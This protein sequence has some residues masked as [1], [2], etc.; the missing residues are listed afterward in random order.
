MTTFLGRRGAALLLYLAIAAFGLTACQGARS[1]SNTLAP[2][3]PTTAAERRGLAYLKAG[4]LNGALEQYDIALAQGAS[5]A[6]IN[7]RKGDAYF[8]AKKW[9]PAFRHFKLAIDESPDWELAQEGAGFAAFELGEF[10]NARVYFERS[11]ELYGKNWV[12]HAFLAVI[13][14]LEGQLEQAKAESETA[15]ELAGDNR[16]LADATMKRAFLRAALLKEQ[17]KDEP[18]TSV[19][20][21]D[22]EAGP[23]GRLESLAPDTSQPG[24]ESA[25]QESAGQAPEK[26]GDGWEVVE[27][28]RI[29]GYILG[30]NG[31]RSV[32]A[33]RAARAATAARA[34]EAAAAQTEKSQQAEAN[35]TGEA[36][37]VEGGNE[38]AGPTKESGLNMS[39]EGSVTVIESP[40]FE[41]MNGTLAA[42]NASLAGHRAN[43]TSANA[44]SLSASASKVSPAN[45][46]AAPSPAPSRQAGESAAAQVSTVAAAA[47]N[48]TAERAAQSAI[49]ANRSAVPQVVEPK[50]AERKKAEPAKA[51]PKPVVPTAAGANAT[52]PRNAPHNATQVATAMSA[53]RPATPRPAADNATQTGTAE[54]ESQQHNA[55]RPRVASIAEPGMV[56]A[57]LESSWREEYRAVNRVADLKKRGIRAHVVP[58][59][60]KNKGLWYRV[61]IGPRKKLQE[62]KDIKEELKKRFGLTDLVILKIPESKF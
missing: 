25:N 45:T 9:K 22:A 56:Y 62:T 1:A 13:Y 4:S 60:V 11:T 40:G 16:V 35:A 48:A 28:R 43:A 36:L 49:S 52:A 15:Y 42:G 7:W 61:M 58:S 57:V 34:D 24:Q 19:A 31:T 53:P 6:V 51:E 33:T 59:Q 39:H 12:P 38:T 46:T 47:K 10:H 21:P 8:S 32:N 55:T 3:E 41:D 20:A 44:T 26:T 14:K 54:A 17:R 50:I 29:P 30:T 5:P 23:L 18:Q 2:P 27:E 37:E